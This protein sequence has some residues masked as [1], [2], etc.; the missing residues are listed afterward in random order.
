M[1]EYA[2][3]REK[4]VITLCSSSGVRIGALPFLKV[5]NLE[6]I[7]VQGLLIY[8]LSIYEGEEEEYTTY[9]TPECRKYIEEYL[10]YRK[11]Y[12][13]VIHQ[14][15]PLLIKEFNTKKLKMHEANPKQMSYHSLRGLTRRLKRLSGVLRS[16]TIYENHGMH[17]YFDTTCIK[18]GV[19]N[20]FVE[21]MMGHRLPGMINQYFKP[22]ESDLLEGNDK[23]LGYI[24]AINE[25]TINDENRLEEELGRVTIQNKNNETI[26]TGKLQE[27]EDQINQLN[28]KYEKEMK[29]LQMVM[30]DK[31]NKLIQRIDTNK[32]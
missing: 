20:L 2:D 4:I 26:I 12:G 11:R 5:G 15:S 9:C 28:E 13:E 27:K 32:I 19:N 23:M 18:A 31:F 14:S 6:S 1:L 25:L 8:R 21:M 16:D 22:T 17:K 10:S 30:E 7:T 29:N 3:L 24:A